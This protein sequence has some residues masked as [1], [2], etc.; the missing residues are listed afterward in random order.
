MGYKRLN[1]A[2]CLVA[3]FTIV[4]RIIGSFFFFIKKRVCLKKQLNHFFSGEKICLSAFP[5]RI[6]SLIKPLLKNSLVVGLL[7]RFTITANFSGDEPGANR[8]KKTFSKSKL[9]F[10]F[11]LSFF[12]ALSLSFSLYLFLS[13]FSFSASSYSSSSFTLSLSLFL[14]LLLSLSLFLFLHL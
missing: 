6:R 12:L 2:C 10:I 14:F 7:P 1:V 13:T 11:L 9:L 3:R 5:K 4:T 8:R